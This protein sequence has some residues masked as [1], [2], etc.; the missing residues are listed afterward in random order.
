MLGTI[1]ATTSRIVPGRRSVLAGL[2]SAG[3]ATLATASLLGGT[4]GRATA[5]VVSLGELRIS[6]DSAETDD[7]TITGVDVD[8]TGHWQ[9]DLTEPDREPDSWQVVVEVGDGSAWAIVATDTG[10]TRF[11]QNAGTWAASGS[12]TGTGLWAP[13]NFAVQSGDSRTVTVPI[14]VTFTAQGPNDQPLAEATVRDEPQVTVTESG[15]EPSAYGE[16]SG[17]GEVI[18]ET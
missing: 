6:D 1:H 15:F 10:D 14:R 13:S 9:Y 17:D 4:P 11:R 12:V 7:G 18:I 5:A 16:T 3:A 2:G 8:L